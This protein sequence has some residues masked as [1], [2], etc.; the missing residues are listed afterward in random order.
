MTPAPPPTSPLPEC[1]VIMPISDHDGYPRGHFQR[2]Y[3]DIITPACLKA[4]YKAVRADDVK[5]S[6]FIHLDILQKLLECPM[7][8]CDL[9]SSNPNVLFELALRQAFDKPVALIQE[10]GTRQI[11]DIA[12]LRYTEYRKERVY[13]EVIEDQTKI[14]TTIKETAE[15]HKSGKGVNSIVKLLALSQ[16][17]KLP[18]ASQDQNADLQRILLAEVGQLRAE[19]RSAIKSITSNGSSSE[20]SVNH[21]MRRYRDMLSSI[22][23]QLEIHESMIG[24]TADACMNPEY[25]MLLSEARRIHREAM[26]N[27]GTRRDR[28]FLMEVDLRL[29]HYQHAMMRAYERS[30]KRN[31]AEIKKTGA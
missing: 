30:P 6:N 5:Q 13:H 24:E 23:S 7:A 10:S 15:A 3:T 4:G 17:A 9:S 2:V 20:D 22:L 18:E 11:F 1:F 14:A 29:D 31:K 12:P 27:A 25:E 19:F 26:V 28:D 16:P 21:A 8:L